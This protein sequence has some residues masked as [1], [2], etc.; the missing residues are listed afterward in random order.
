VTKTEDSSLEAH[1]PYILALRPGGVLLPIFPL[2]R[3]SIP[4]QSSNDSTVVGVSHLVFMFNFRGDPWS[5]PGGRHP[6]EAL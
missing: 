2:K 5:T 3:E 1:G 4:I 6:F